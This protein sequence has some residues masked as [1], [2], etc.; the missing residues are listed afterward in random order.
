MHMSVGILRLQDGLDYSKVLGDEEDVG[1]GHAVINAGND[2]SHVKPAVST[3][4]LPRNESFM[5]MSAGEFF[6][7]F[8]LISSKRLIIHERF[9]V[10]TEW[11]HFLAVR[12]LVTRHGKIM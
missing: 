11:M 2:A 1:N 8:F 12:P 9:F 5:Q 4:F 10:I 3:E 7:S 6:S